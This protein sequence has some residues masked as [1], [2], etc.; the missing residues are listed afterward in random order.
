M[1]WVI[2]MNEIDYSDKEEWKGFISDYVIPLR[3]SADALVEYWN[4]LKR[5]IDGVEIGGMGEDL[6]KALLG[7]VDEEGNY[8]EG[9]IAKFYK[10]F[11]G[12]SLSVELPKYAAAAKEEATKGIKGMVREMDS[13]T[14]PNVP[15]FIKF[16]LDIAGQTKKIANIALSKGIIDTV[17]GPS[18]EIRHEDFLANQEDAVERVGDFYN[19]CAKIVPN[20]NNYTLFVLSIRN[21]ASR[22]LEE[23]YP[24]FKF[25][26]KFAELQSM[27]G[28]KSLF[29]PD[30]AD[31]AKKAEYAIWHLPDGSFGGE[32]RK[33]YELIWNYSN[34]FKELVSQYFEGTT[35]LKKEFIED[36][37][38]KVLGLPSEEVEYEYEK[39]R[40]VDRNRCWIQ[41]SNQ[42]LEGFGVQAHNLFP[43]LLHEPKKPVSLMQ[44]LDELSPLL[45]VGLINIVEVLYEANIIRFESIKLEK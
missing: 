38:V 3:D 22:Y 34:V 14:H 29:V 12:V 43:K 19:K 33:L 18:S 28:L 2:P 30:I 32:V 7:G 24:Q 1:A 20:F 11:F 4:Y 37:K 25:K 40:F 17:A 13:Q 39:F 5:K 35:D 42:W 23:A 26:N 27:L 45:F 8:L 6:K 21:I 41:F 16:I 31:G 9:S 36:A 15:Y 44:I 10:D